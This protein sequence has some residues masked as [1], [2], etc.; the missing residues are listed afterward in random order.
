MYKR[1]LLLALTVLALVAGCAKEL[2]SPA[3]APTPLPSPESLPTSATETATVATATVAPTAD[4]AP[5]SE[6]PVGGSS[7]GPAS[8]VVEPLDFP[9]APVPPVTEADQVYGPPGAS[10]TFIEYADFQ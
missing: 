3:S 1:T 9:V 6:T 8:C 5:V 10:I 4:D 7:S 2:A